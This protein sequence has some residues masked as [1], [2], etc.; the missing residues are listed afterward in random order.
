MLQ[1]DKEWNT[2]SRSFRKQLMEHHKQINVRK[3]YAWNLILL[4]IL[5]LN[6]IKKAKKDTVFEHTSVFLP[7]FSFRSHNNSR[8]PV[9]KTNTRKVS[10]AKIRQRGDK[11]LLAGH[12]CYCFDPKCVS[13][14]WDIWHWVLCRPQNVLLSDALRWAF[15]R[16]QILF[17]LCCGWVAARLWLVSCLLYCRRWR[18]WDLMAAAFTPWDH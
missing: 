15:R 11:C 8:K 17:T 2:K 1:H 3:K 10:L 13:A 18:F 7:L 5:C 6:W 16:V 12:K 4:M 14:D 9:L